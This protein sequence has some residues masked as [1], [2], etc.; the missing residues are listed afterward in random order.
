MYHAKWYLKMV[1][2]NLY[3]N[4]LSKTFGLIIEIIRGNIATIS[5]FCVKVWTIYC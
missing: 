3:V 2:C 5:D 4:N 1:I